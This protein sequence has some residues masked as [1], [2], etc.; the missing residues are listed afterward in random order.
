MLEKINIEIEE[1]INTCYWVKVT[2]VLGCKVF[3]FFFIQHY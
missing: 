2:P 1:F 3:M